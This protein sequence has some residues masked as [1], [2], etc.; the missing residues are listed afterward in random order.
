VTRQH[1]HQDEGDS[2][3]ASLSPHQLALVLARLHDGIAVQ[4]LDGRLIYAN[5]KAARMAGFRAGEEM[6]N[7]LAE[8]F[9]E[10]FELLDELGQPLLP[11]DLP[12]R[13]VLRG[14]SDVETVVR[15]RERATDHEYWSL[16]SASLVRD[17]AGKP[18][19]VVNTFH[20]ITARMEQEAALQ[21]SAR[22]LEELS[23]EMEQTNEE[24]RARTEEA[25]W[26]ATRARFLA[27][28]GQVL[29]SSLDYEDTLTAVV[30]LAVPR[31]ADWCTMH[32]VDDSGEFRRLEVA[33]ADPRRLA[34]A[35]EYEKLYPQ[36]QD[37]TSAVYRVI[38]SG[39]PELLADV[40]DELL[41][42]AA[43]TEDQLARLRSLGF[44]SA[45]VVPLIA[46]ERTLGALTLI[47]AESARRYTEQDLET[48]QELARRAALAIDTARLYNEAHEASQAKSQFIAVMS[49]ELRTPLN[50]V[51]G[52]TELLEGGIP[53]PLNEKQLAH[54]GR[55]RTGAWILTQTIDEILTFSRVDAGREVAHPHQI[56][57][58]QVLNE[59]ALLVEPTAV[60][61]GLRFE[62]RPAAESVILFIDSHKLR[63]ILLNLLSNAIK[64]TDEGSV[65]LSAEVDDE[66]VR[67]RVADTGPGIPSAARERVFEPFTQLDSSN[68]REKGGTGLG[69]TVARSLARLLGGDLVIES[70]DA[71]GSTFVLDMPRTAREP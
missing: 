34:A 54:I 55:I 1:P 38:R 17:E 25:V 58:T 65:T 71:T 30:R 69:L 62:F 18:L 35:L 57:L 41:A 43:R 60:A 7:V 21:A 40:T 29:A 33:H 3:A 36:R 23:I 8:D 4:A 63:Q 37:E 28:A 10:R 26:A 32:V 52:Y 2:E 22:Q 56:A 11:D 47:A 46:H 15:Y 39:N 31:I 44:R 12:G 13:R 50:A 16:I 19:V 68:T 9:V 6:L 66:R 45:I 27:E 64:F 51:I 48:A 14:E 61:K 59:A 20:D 24:L 70:S 42:A 49:H 53:G 5:D 67:F